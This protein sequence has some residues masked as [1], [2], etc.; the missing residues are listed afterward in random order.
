MC[1]SLNEM[2]VFYTIFSVLY[3]IDVSDNDGDYCKAHIM[4]IL[5]R[6][7]AVRSSSSVVEFIL[8]KHRAALYSMDSLTLSSGKMMLVLSSYGGCMSSSWCRC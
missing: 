2:S 8:V 7:L 1:I 6:V 5:L 4:V 3:C